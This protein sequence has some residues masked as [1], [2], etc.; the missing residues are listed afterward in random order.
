MEEQEK[1]EMA[2]NKSSLL[3]HLEK[4]RGEVFLVRQSNDHQKM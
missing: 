3:A 1:A 2:E 4:K